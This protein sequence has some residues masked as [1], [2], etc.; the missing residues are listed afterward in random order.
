MKGKQRALRIAI[1]R[2]IALAWEIENFSR[3]GNKLKNLKHYLS[4]DDDPERRQSPA[5]MIAA[6]RAIAATTKK[7]R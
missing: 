7:G 2:D 5:D 4:K 6:L 1:D 3:A